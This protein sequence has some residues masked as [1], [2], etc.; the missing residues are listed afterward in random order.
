MFHS[1][2][3]KLTAWYLLII[4]IVS[5]SFSIAVYRILTFELDRVERVQRLRPPRDDDRRFPILDPELVSETKDRLKIILILINSGILVSSAAAGYFLAGRTLQPI[6]VMVDEQNR[7]I[8]DSSHE[9]RTPLTS[10]R[11]E[12]EV[13]LRDNNLNIQQAK[14]LLRSNLED[15]KGLQQLSD[16]LIKL[17]QYQKGHNN[18]HLTVCILPDIVEE[19][20]KKISGLAKSKKINIKKQ[21]QDISVQAEKSSL[22]ELLTILLDNAIKYSPFASTVTLTVEPDGRFAKI[23]VAD[24][25]CGIDPSDLPH[26]F[27]RF[28]RADK[29]RTKSDAPGYGLGLSIAKQITER[30]GGT[31]IVE[32]RVGKGSSFIVKLIL[33][34]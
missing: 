30:L 23:I 20:L 8:T 3:I 22:V 32:S 12:I 15:V 29:S 28:Y 27:D 6:K 26:I 2:R 17:A 19:A 25:G 4:T 11:S 14:K 1:T 5:I 31:I 7:F 21:V 34:L 9:L 10:L 13:N 16:S 24:Q 33:S 18:V